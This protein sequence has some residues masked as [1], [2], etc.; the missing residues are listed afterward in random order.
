MVLNKTPWWPWHRVTQIGKFGVFKRDPGCLFNCPSPSCTRNPTSLLT[1]TPHC[2]IA[3]TFTPEC[4]NEA[5]ER[6]TKKLLTYVFSSPTC[7]TPL[8]RWGEAR[9]VNE[10]ITTL[11]G[12]SSGQPLSIEPFGSSRSA[13]TLYG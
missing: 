8:C 7:S 9:P 10:R 5:W 12:P 3:L 2:G 11:M 6:G 4:Q 1:R 13:C